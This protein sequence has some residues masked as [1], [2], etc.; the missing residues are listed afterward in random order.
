MLSALLP[1]SVTLGEPLSLCK[2]VDGYLMQ[3]AL[4][5][6]EIWKSWY[7]K[8]KKININA[9]VFEMQ[10]CP[11]RRKS[12]AFFS[13]GVDSFFT[14]LRHLACDNTS[15][16]TGLD[17]LLFVRGFDIP[18]DNN[19]LFDQ[20]E[21]RQIAFAG[22]IQKQHLSIYT[23]LRETRFRRSGW[24]ILSHGAALASVGLVLEKRY[25]QILVAST[26]DY[27]NLCPWGSHPETDPLFSTKQMKIVHDGADY[28][29]VQK[30]VFIAHNASALKSL[31]VCY[32]KLSDQ[33]CSLCNKCYRTMI[34]L[35]LLGKL[36]EASLFEEG[37]FDLERVSSIYSKDYSDRMFLEE[38]RQFA[39]EQGELELANNIERSFKHTTNISNKLFWINRI[40]F[41][42]RRIRKW[43]LRNS[44]Y[45]R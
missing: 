38:V 35:K 6:I 20:V 31:R 24:G 18:L 30:T 5:V 10:Q 1:L 9:P 19:E 17:D 12:A 14:V 37:L 45:D 15:P 33:N 8:L 44:I 26:H 22:K 21:K 13:S 41:K 27:D 16:D 43:I 7:P 2:P 34:T 39:V 36:K 4:K 28:T 42:R 23:N 40:P 32:G 11:E 25:K 3:N 29:R